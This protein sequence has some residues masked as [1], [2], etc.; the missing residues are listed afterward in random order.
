MGVIG[1]QVNVP[2]FQWFGLQCID[3]RRKRCE[4]FAHRP[5]TVTPR[6]ENIQINGVVLCL[7]RYGRQS[8]G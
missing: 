3:G 1:L 5:V 8:I 2:L 4:G 7:F 6:I